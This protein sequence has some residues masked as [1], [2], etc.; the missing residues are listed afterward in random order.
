MLMIKGGSKQPYK[1]EHKFH[2]YKIITIKITVIMRI[3][4]NKLTG[5]SRLAGGHDRNNDLDLV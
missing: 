2:C 5:P 4:I 1:I 3:K